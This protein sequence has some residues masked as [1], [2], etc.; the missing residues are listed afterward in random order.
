VDQGTRDRGARKDYP[1]SLLKDYLGSPK[2]LPFRGIDP[3]SPKLQFTLSTLRWP[4]P[5][6]MPQYDSGTLNPESMNKQ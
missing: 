4:V 5:A 2:N 3:G 1:F 6:K